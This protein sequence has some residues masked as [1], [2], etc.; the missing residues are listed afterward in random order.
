M[1]QYPEP[2]V[3]EAERVLVVDDEAD[4]VH[5]CTKVLTAKGYRAEG[6]CNGLEALE[7]AKGQSFDLLLAD[8]M[9][10]EISGL[11]LFEG[12]KSRKPD[13][14]GVVITGYGTVDMAIE[15]MRAGVRDF[16]CKPFESEDLL[17][18]VEHAL[19]ATRFLRE[20]IQ[21]TAL[22]PVLEATRRFR[23][24]V[25]LDDLLEDVLITA[26]RQAHADTGGLYLRAASASG[27]R[28]AIGHAGNQ[29]EMVVACRTLCSI[30]GDRTE[31]FVI[32]DEL[33]TP[34]QA[35]RLLDS[36]GVSS[37]LCFPLR[38]KGRTLGLL[39]L[40]KQPGSERFT[41]R[42]AELISILGAQAAAAIE[43]ARLFDELEK[44]Q[45]NL[46]EWNQELEKRVEERTTAL[47]E[48]QEHL[49]RAEK[50]AV[51]GKLGAGIAHE[52]RNP[53]GV[54]S[55]SVY[56]LNL[57]SGDA[58]S[59][60][61]KHLGIIQREVARSNKIITDLMSFVR[62]AQSSKEVV[63]VNGLIE[64]TLKGMEIPPA[65]IV[66]T[67]LAE[68]LPNAVVDP[69][70]IRQVFINLMTNAV[71]GMS[72]NGT[73]SVTTRRNDGCVEI[74]FSDTGCGI[75]PENMN[76]LFEPLFST[77]AQGIGLGLAISKMLVE[78]QGGRI[79]GR[80]NPAQGATF[81]VTL[82]ARPHAEGDGKRN[83]E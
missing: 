47:R 20:K 25:M 53:L 24:T 76:R 10:P 16:L 5:F 37:M 3:E 64:E 46:E 30:F 36:L 81:V 23:S 17:E 55:N 60:V 80:N 8:L 71:E 50:L 65:V 66:E 52:L 67:G 39:N 6:T 49:V 44:A 19:A 38:D 58:D 11:D 7:M 2:D 77:K 59:K 31:A 18:A 42:D 1:N 41:E 82:P 56:Y 74:G 15:A 12:V 32:G 61:K 69:G 21:L 43:S 29:N 83:P 68:D 28:A 73:I 35:Q 51:I 40:C 34:P 62:V 79:R 14:A 75:S 72:G 78:S 45:A 70:K 54:I 9:M 4:I 48:A 63:D 27:L 57:K 13:T 26:A 22:M 33:E